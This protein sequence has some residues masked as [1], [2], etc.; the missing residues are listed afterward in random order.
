MERASWVPSLYFPVQLPWKGNDTLTTAL[1]SSLLR[2]ADQNETPMTP[3]VLLGLED[4]PAFALSCR[5]FLGTP[6]G[7][8]GLPHFARGNIPLPSPNIILRRAPGLQQLH[9]RPY[10]FCPLGTWNRRP[11]CWDSYWFPDPPPMKA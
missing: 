11:C 6:V 7:R 4:H 5:G 8:Y 9:L 2:R 1:L 10:D 3:T